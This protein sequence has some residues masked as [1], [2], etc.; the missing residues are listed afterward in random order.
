MIETEFVD[1][2]IKGCAAVDEDGLVG[3]FGWGGGW[4]GC[5]EGESEV[6]CAEEGESG[7]G[8]VVWERCCF[9]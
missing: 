5:G 9:G 2:H 6:G 8:I 1:T 3:V 7:C 4:E